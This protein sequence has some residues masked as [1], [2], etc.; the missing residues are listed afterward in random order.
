MNWPLNPEV[1]QGIARTSFYGTLGAADQER[2][3]PKITQSVDQQDL[4]VTYTSFGEAPE[5]RQLSGSVASTG[6]RQA[7]GVKDYKLVG[8]VVEWEQTVEIPRSVI[9]TN[10]PEVSRKMSQMARK[11]SIF[12]DRR[13]VGTALSASTAG[14]DGVS[15]YNDAHPESGSNQDNNFTPTA[16]TGTKPTV[17]ELEAEIELEIAALKGFTDDKGTPV[18]EGVMSYTILVPLSFEYL[19][20]SVL[21]PLKGQAPGLDIS[22]ATGRFRG[23]FTVI[24][25]SF[26]TADRHYIFC[27]R[28]DTSAVA[29]LK[30]KDYEFVTNIG[31]DSDMW[32]FKQVAVFS[33]YARMEFVPWDWKVTARAV[34]Q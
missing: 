33:S 3:Y 1:L 28:P 2:I 27:N 16:A 6:E 11:A 10:T 7:H 21:E 5:P 30:N 14:Y 12:L 23:M 26:I 15:L 17:A 13:L 18:N 31:T 8:T 4:T 34:W 24:A 32:R 29:Y 22:G 19:Y 25:S 9:E 20:R